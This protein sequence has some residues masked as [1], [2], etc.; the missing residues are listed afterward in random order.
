MFIY[1]SV[2]Q[3][4]DAHSTFCAAIPTTPLLDFVIIPVSAHFSHWLPTQSLIPIIPLWICKG[5]CWGIMQYSAATLHY[6]PQVPS[7]RAVTLIFL[8]TEW[9]G[10]LRICGITFSWILSVRENRQPTKH[11]VSLTLPNL[12]FPTFFRPIQNRRLGLR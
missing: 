3:Q 11:E 6:T 9:P 10:G 1:T 12:Y 4:H 7:L 8:D 2:A 5:G